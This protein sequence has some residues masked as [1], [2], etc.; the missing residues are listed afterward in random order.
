M[1][2][3]KISEL[4][5]LTTPTDNAVFPV[6]DNTG[7][8]TK[9]LSWANIKT[10]LKNYFDTLY[11]AQIKYA[12][13]SDTKSAGTNGGTLSTSTWNTRTLNT[14]DNDADNIVSLSSNQFTLQAGTYRIRAQVPG[15]AVNTHKAKL[16]N[17]TDSADTLIGTSEHAGNENVV[18]NS[19]VVGEF[20]ITA[21]KTFELQHRIATSNGVADAGHA[22]NV[23]VNEVYTIVEIWKIR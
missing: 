15:Y 23:G 18:T 13:L 2:S 21:T 17:V 14:K 5:E 12:K 20:T 19:V 9:K 4:T 6:V 1:A 10:A 22:W 3:K 7:P 16:R 8:S 11:G